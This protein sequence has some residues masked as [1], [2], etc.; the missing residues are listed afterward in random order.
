M[1]TIALDNRL[2]VNLESSGVYNTCQALPIHQSTLTF[3][4]MAGVDGLWSWYDLRS[5]IHKGGALGAVGGAITGAIGGAFVGGPPGG[6][7]GAAAGAA[8]GAA[9]GAATGA[10]AYIYDQITAPETCT[11]RR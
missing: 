1:N 7:I 5:A 6:I 3:E 9:A 10:G 4:E 11:C 2:G 8:V